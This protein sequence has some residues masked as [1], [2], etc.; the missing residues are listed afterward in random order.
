MP[1]A[2]LVHWKKI[3]RGSHHRAHHYP[4][5][6]AKSGERPTP[7]NYHDNHYG[8]GCHTDNH[9][10]AHTPECHQN[11]VTNDNDHQL[12]FTLNNDP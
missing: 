5:N 11:N 7:T 12:A 6:Y 1:P 2:R 4:E 10:P 8:S 3:L 9:W